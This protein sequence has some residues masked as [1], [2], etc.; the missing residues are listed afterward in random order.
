MTAPERAMWRPV[1][2]APHA[3]IVLLGWKTAWPEV[4]LEFEVGA[5]SGGWR[6]DGWSTLHTHGRAQFFR[7]LPLPP[8]DKA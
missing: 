3:E 8:E 5:A 7:P 1:E 6:R 4:M 2:E